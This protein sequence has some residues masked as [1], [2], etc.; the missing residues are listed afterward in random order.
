MALNKKL[1]HAWQQVSG[2][3]LNDSP[4]Q[5]ANEHVGLLTVMARVRSVALFLGISETNARKL[6]HPLRSIQLVPLFARGPA[7]AYT[8]ES[9]HSPEITKIFRKPTEGPG[10][11]VCRNSEDNRSIK[12]GVDQIVAGRLLGYPQCCIDAQQ[13]G[14]AGL[15]DALVRGWIRKFGNDPEKIGH[16]W[17]EDQKVHIDF[18]PHDRVP[19]TM[20]LF[21]FV[22]HVACE[23]CLTL[24]DSATAAMNSEYKDLLVGVDPTLHDYL[25]RLG[26]RVGERS[27]HQH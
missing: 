4:E 26:R 14:Y 23:S 19:R 21:P 6:M 12:K 7:M 25:E 17:L 24:Q 13:Q 22:Q 20:A 18:E 27:H 15:E 8:W 3:L 1:R 2:I 9:P 16:A 5:D 10:L 11:W